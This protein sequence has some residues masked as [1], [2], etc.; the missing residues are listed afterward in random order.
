MRHKLALAFLFLLAVALISAI[1]GTDPTTDLDVELG[2]YPLIRQSCLICGAVGTGKTT[3]LFKEESR[4]KIRRGMP[5]KTV[6]P[7]STVL[8]V[9]IPAI[10]ELTLV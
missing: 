10:G 6:P 4:L 5:G 1:V 2:L 7:T 9:I 8:A 3:S